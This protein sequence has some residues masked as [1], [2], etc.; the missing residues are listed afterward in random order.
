MKY[1]FQ[2][3]GL[4]LCIAIAPSNALSQCVSPQ[5][6]WYLDIDNDE[7]GSV[8]H[9]TAHT[10]E[11]GI[12]AETVPD[13]SAA[14]LSELHISN[15]QYVTS[16]NDACPLNGT[17]TSEGACGCAFS[18]TQEDDSDDDGTPDCQDACPNDVDK[19]IPGTCGCG[20]PETD[21][22]G[23]TVVDCIDEC[24]DHAN[25]VYNSACGCA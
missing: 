1:F 16:S 10:T 14:A 8:I 11:G 24:P 15:A 6:L 5:S 21:S 19:I 13:V 2:L 18:S 20:T 7:V 23:D 12:C 25:G 3:I 17:K 9:I 4:L 22:D